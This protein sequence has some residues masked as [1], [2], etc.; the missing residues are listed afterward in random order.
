MD[1]GEE[2]GDGSNDMLGMVM[3]VVIGDA[4]RLASVFVKTA[5]N[6]VES[7]RHCDLVEAICK[8]RVSNEEFH[9]NTPNSRRAE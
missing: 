9:P 4:F 2:G 6:G 8:V 1:G 3:K 7:E 5:L